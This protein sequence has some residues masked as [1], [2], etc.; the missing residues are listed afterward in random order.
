M[1]SVSRITAGDLEYLRAVADGR[2][3]WRSVSGGVG[4][5]VAGERCT[6]RGRRVATMGFTRLV[7]D[8]RQRFGRGWVELSPRGWL[9]LGCGPDTPLAE[10]LTG[11]V[12]GSRS[13]PNRKD[14]T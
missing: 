11:D 7:T 8:Y 13:N 3:T 9:A 5:S 1:G 4:Y 12:V 10:V 6:P 14:R 2:V